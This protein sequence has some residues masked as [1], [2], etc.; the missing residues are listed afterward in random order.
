MS[1]VQVDRHHEDDAAVERAKRQ[2]HSLSEFIQTCQAVR[3]RADFCAEVAP[4]LSEILPHEAL[5]CAVVRLS[6]LRTQAFSVVT[7]WD[8]GNAA[9]MSPGSRLSCPAISKWLQVRQPVCAEAGPLHAPHILAHGVVEPGQ[10]NVCCFVFSGVRAWTAWETYLLR[11]VVPHLHYAMCMTGDFWPKVPHTLTTRE[12]EVLQWV[13]KGKSN[14]EIASI[15]G[16]SPW[17]IKIHVAS[18]LSKLNAA[19]RGHAVAKAMS[20][21]LLAA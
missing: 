7:G 20:Q 17:T 10:E 15:L 18:V 14:P 9:A 11:F 19:N 1:L 16:V 8:G 13:C 21:G 12:R 6:D 5:S 3:T 4:R 2:F